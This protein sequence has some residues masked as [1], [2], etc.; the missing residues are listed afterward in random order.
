MKILCD[1]ALPNSL[2]VFSP[3]GEVVLKNGRE[4][5]ALDVQDADVMIIRSVT[6]V[7]EGLLRHAKKLK[8]VGTATAGTDHLDTKLLDRMGI[9]YA[10][11]PGSNAQSVGDYVLSVLLV[12]AQRYSLC[13]EGKSVG[14][15]G[16][17]HVGSYVEA[18]A[19]ALKLKVVKCDPPRFS[20]GDRTCNASLEDALQC[21]IV[22]LHVPLLKNSDNCTYHM[23][24]KDRLMSLKKGAV[25][26]NASRGAVVD[27]TALHDVLKKRHDLKVWLDVFEGEPEIEEKDLLSLVEGATPHIAGYSFESKR[28]ASVMLAE[29]MSST[30]S[31]NKKVSYTMPVPEICTVSL[32]D[33]KS[34]DYDLI[35]RLVFSVYDVRRDSHAFKNSFTGAKSFDLMR[36]NYRE[37]R[38]LC[39]VEIINTR[40]EIATILS[41]LGFTV[42]NS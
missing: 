4:I 25:L 42:K 40:K 33:V 1:K 24:D 41:D 11:A 36:Q 18:K 15:I 5:S 20:A 7:D 21:D 28:R 9:K 23:I 13:F 30:L 2:E 38:E 22:T 16:C 26:I 19:R 37:R 10:S 14:I 27:N 3:F 32:G 34:L 35:S 6:K 39:S 8:Y 12:L 17:G 29:D 31:L